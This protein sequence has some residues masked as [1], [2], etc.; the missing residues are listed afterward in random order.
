MTRLRSIAWRRLQEVFDAAAEVDP[1]AR[2]AFLDEQCAGDPLLREQVESLL[3]HYDADPDRLEAAMSGGLGAS[4]LTPAPM[5]GQ[6]LGPY[7][8]ERELGEGGMGTVY[9]AVRDD[10]VYRKQVAI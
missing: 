9:L 10:E 5:V 3:V 4:S 1:A 6:R 2:G 8:I 7:R